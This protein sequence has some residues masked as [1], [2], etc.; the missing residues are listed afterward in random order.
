MKK[1]MILAA[2]RG[3]RMGVLTDNLPK[4]LL[5]VGGHYLIDYA[6]LAIKRAG[7]QEIIINI[8]WR[9]EKIKAALESGEHYG[10]KI[11]YSEEQERLETGGGIFQALP[12][13]GPQAFLVMSS[14]I[15]TD[16]PLQ[17]LPQDPEGLAHLVMVKNPSWHPGGDYGLCNEKI[18]LDASEKLTYA[19]FGIFRPALFAGCL[20]GHFRLTKVF[21]PAIAAGKISGEEYQGLWYNMSTAQDIKEFERAREDSNLRP[22]AS[23]TN[24]LSS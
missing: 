19:S 4:A 13:L 24:T 2:G 20:P 17:D 7:I 12:L 6:I 18:I 14:D 11:L 16:Y 1:A 22:L 23:E 5:K 10:V 9:A 3:E 8:S 15:I 21:A